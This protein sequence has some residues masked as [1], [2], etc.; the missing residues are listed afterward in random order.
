MKKTVKKLVDKADKRV[1]KTQRHKKKRREIMG[2]DAI[3]QDMRHK[4]NVAKAAIDP[5]DTVA[6]ARTRE[7]IRRVGEYK[8]KKFTGMA[9]G[10]MTCCRGM[11]SAKRGGRFRKDG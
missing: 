11:G 10:G 1:K 4:K 7:A 6:K 5:D 8:K 3:R 9:A 2:E